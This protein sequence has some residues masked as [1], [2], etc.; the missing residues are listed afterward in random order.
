MLS[1]PGMITLALGADDPNTFLYCAGYPLRLHEPVLGDT[2]GPIEH[3]TAKLAI[4]VTPLPTGR[5][6]VHQYC[7]GCERVGREAT[8]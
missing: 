6:A 2:S 5:L 3:G 7:A 8:R 4:L 1:A